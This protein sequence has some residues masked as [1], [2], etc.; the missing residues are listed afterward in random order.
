MSEAMLKN[1]YAHAQQKDLDR[2]RTASNGRFTEEEKQWKTAK[3]L[4]T[5]FAAIRSAQKSNAIVTTLKAVAT[6]GLK[7]TMHKTTESV[8]EL[9]P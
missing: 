7:R 4:E 5:V 3:T 9:C 6:A 8:R 2:F 1:I